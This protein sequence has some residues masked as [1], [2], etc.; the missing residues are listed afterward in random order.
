M[1]QLGPATQR[2]ATQSPFLHNV[3]ELLYMLVV[4]P[5]YLLH[6]IWVVST[7]PK[8][9]LLSLL[10][11]TCAASESIMLT[12]YFNNSF[13]LPHPSSSVVS[14]PG[15]CFPITL[16]SWKDAPPTQPRR[17]HRPTTSNADNPTIG[18]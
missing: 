2:N 17:G 1:I 6:A 9:I 13:R 8:S 5:S 18:I 10:D 15:A 3:F 12:L 7:K 14:I 4:H 11:S 16:P